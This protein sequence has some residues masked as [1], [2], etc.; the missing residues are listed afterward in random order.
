MSFGALFIIAQKVESWQQRTFFVPGR[1]GL[2]GQGR[3]GRGGVVGL[4]RRSCLS[5]RRV[6]EIH[7]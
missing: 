3:A 1:L 7:I 2:T 5:H 6:P 4:L